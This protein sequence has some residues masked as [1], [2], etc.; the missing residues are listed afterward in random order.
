MLPKRRRLGAAIFVRRPQN[1]QFSS[2]SFGSYSEHPFMD[3][4]S[5][6]T[7]LRGAGVGLLRL[8]LLES[9]LPVRIRAAGAEDAKARLQ[10]VGA[11]VAAARSS[12]AA[13]CSPSMCPA[14]IYPGKIL[15]DRN[16]EAPITR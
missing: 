2:L 11:L 15:S 6:R 8:P 13:V 1:I 9:M 10:S 12:A 14:R 5:R 4:L 16:R 7:F 3:R